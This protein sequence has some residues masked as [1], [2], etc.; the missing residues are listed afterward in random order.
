MSPLS[1]QIIKVKSSSPWSTIKDLTFED[2]ANLILV[3]NVSLKASEAN[4]RE[5]FAFCGKI[6]SFEMIRYCVT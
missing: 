1:P 5:F 4:V 6:T 2:S 3:E